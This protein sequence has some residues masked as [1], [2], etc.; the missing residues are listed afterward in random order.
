MQTAPDRCLSNGSSDEEYRV[1]R[2][3]GSI[4]WV[5]DRGFVVQGEDGQPDRLAGVA[6]DITD[7]KQ[8]EYEREQLLHREQAA[9]ADA[10]AAN[11]MK[12]EFLAVLSHELRSPL[13]PIL[14]WSRLLQS[15]KLSP[16]KTQEALDTIDRNAK[17]QAKL[18]DDLLDVSRILRGKLSLN[19][20]SVDLS[21]VIAAACDTVRLA[22]E[23]KGIFIHTEISAKNRT[24]LGD[25]SR[26][27]QV[28]WNLLS[29]AV[30]F[31]PE[32]GRV[33]I[34]LI[35]VGTQAHIQITD[36][37]KGISADF[38]PY[39]FDRFRQEDGS[40]TRKF[41]GLGLG[42]AIVR[43]LVEL[44]GGTVTVGS[45]GEGQG[46]TF[47]V[48]LPIVPDAPQIP[49]LEQS[50]KPSI[51]LSGVR[52]LVVDDDPDSREVIRFALAQEHALVRAAASGAEALN[53]FS[54]APPDLLVS[55]IGMPDMDGYMLIQNIRNLPPEQGGHTPAIALTAYAGEGDQQRAIAAGFQRHV[56]KP[57]DPDAVVA[58]VVELIQQNTTLSSNG[59]K[60]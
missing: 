18:V 17:L 23:A 41:G 36:T 34:S 38:L 5:R 52:I 9:R 27:Q 30:K 42:L 20:T 3:D 22:A 31:T 49:R 15:G 25:P 10:E 6:E 1:V 8:A 16:A 33:D 53:G 14:G 19:V 43:Q 44:H 28:I 35:Q 37:G 21:L 50:G 40:T 58:I 24:V 29:N 60:L 47:T 7:R 13:N 51:D 55:D 32:G 2:P 54:Q 46:A 57:I 48:Q 45:G 26:L 12:D 4:R 59:K 56:A 11:R 39:V